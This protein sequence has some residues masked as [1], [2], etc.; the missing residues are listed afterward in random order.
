MDWPRSGLS[1]RDAVGFI[2]EAMY[3]GF[4]PVFA[5]SMY[6]FR[7]FQEYFPLHFIATSKPI[8]PIGLA[9][10]SRLGGVGFLFLT[11]N[12]SDCPAHF[13]QRV[14]PGLI[15]D[16]TGTF[17]QWFSKFEKMPVDSAPVYVTS[18]AGAIRIVRGEFLGES[19]MIIADNLDCLWSEQS[20]GHIQSAILIDHPAFLLAVSDL[21]INEE[22][23]R[24]GKPALVLLDMGNGECVYHGLVPEDSSRSPRDEVLNILERL[25]INRNV[26]HSPL[27]F[28]I[29][30]MRKVR[31]L[32]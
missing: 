18:L 10:V 25:L 31:R 12:G 4:A 17:T 6:C 16:I 9:E 23:Q 30:T 15:S 7:L 24:I 26:I 32:G 22:L 3:E 28:V 2:G 1:I 19:A 14:T 21:G 8:V 13:L 11:R 20:R 29:K 5:D 27:E